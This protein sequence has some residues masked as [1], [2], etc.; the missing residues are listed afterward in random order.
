MTQHTRRNPVSHKRTASL[1]A[2]AAGV[3]TL[4]LAAFLV[5][6]PAGAATSPTAN[7]GKDSAWD[8]GYTARYTVAAGDSAALNG[9]RGEFHLP[10]RKPVRTLWGSLLTTSGQHFSLVEP[11]DNGS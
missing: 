8:T 1:A 2:L 9:W 3:A 5:S 6:T 10:A 11:E 4:L 7:F